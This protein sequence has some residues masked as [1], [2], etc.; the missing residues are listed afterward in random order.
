MRWPRALDWTG[1]RQN[2]ADPLDWT[3]RRYA[4]QARRCITDLIEPCG[5]EHT[6]P[7]EW[8]FLGWLEREGFQHDFSLESDLEG[9]ELPFDDDDVLSTHPEY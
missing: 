4:R 6:A 3:T 8:R 1:R 5:T 9:P 7:A 2:P